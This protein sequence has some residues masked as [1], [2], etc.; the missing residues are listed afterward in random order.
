MKS[1][2]LLSILVIFAVTASIFAKDIS[3]SK[4]EQVAVNFLFE[5]SSQYG[6]AINYYDLNISES[7]LVDQSYYVVNFENGWVVV[8][9]NDV[10]VPVLG[11]NFS[12]SFPAIENQIDNFHS[13]MQTYVDQVN[14]IRENNVEAE[15][16]VVERWNI[17]TTSTPTTLNLKGDRDMEPLLT[18]MWNQDSPYNAMCP[19]YEGGP[20]G[21]V[22]VGCVATAMSMIMHYWRYPLQ[23]SGSHS[24]NRPPFGTLSANFG[25]ANYDWDGMTDVIDGKF[26]WEIA[27]IGFHAGVSVDMMYAFEGGASSAAYSNE[28]PYAMINYFNYQSITQYMQ[29]IG[30]PIATWESMMQTELD[31]LRPIYYSGSSTEGG[32]AF[33]CDGYQGMNYYH[34]NFGW[35]GQS[36]GFYSLQDVGGFYSG[37]AMIRNIY[38]GD[39]AYPYIAT[40]QTDLST[41]VGSFTDGSGP[42]E[43]YPTGISSTGI[44]HHR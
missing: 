11:Y 35:G 32:H 43:D 4:A 15:D 39:A 28:V 37:Q 10:M 44:N 38:P 26:V 24:Y 5:K 3:L 7:Y 23:G 29:K 21:R 22:Y 19:E 9:A 42:A 20:G 30:Y 18:T 13:W 27:E 8:A 40:G 2:V 12:G 6:D 33:V 34:F 16:N 17:Y 31:S 41:L 25:E 36:N 14:F 1:K